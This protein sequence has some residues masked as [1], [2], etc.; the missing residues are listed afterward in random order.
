[1][2][3]GNEKDKNQMLNQAKNRTNKREQF[4]ASPT[5]S[6]SHLVQFLLSGLQLNVIP[7]V[8]SPL[9]I[10]NQIRLS[11]CHVTFPIARLFSIA[12]LP[13]PWYT[14]ILPVYRSVSTHP[15]LPLGCQNSTLYLRFP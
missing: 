11:H 5:Y 14:H 6:V 2:G 7:M 12:A 1:M 15:N 10:L 4:T 9:N 13:P 3:R 8:G